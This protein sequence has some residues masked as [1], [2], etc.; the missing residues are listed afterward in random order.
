MITGVLNE[1]LLGLSN[2]LTLHQS[3]FRASDVLERLRVSSER[4]S[5]RCSFFS[6]ERAILWCRCQVAMDGRM[7]HLNVY[8][9]TCLCPYSQSHVCLITDYSL[10]IPRVI[11]LH[12]FCTGL[13]TFQASTYCFWL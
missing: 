12:H 7:L 9:Y 1:S 6:R 5:F 13:P 10:H 11:C 3:R 4:D 8:T 2:A